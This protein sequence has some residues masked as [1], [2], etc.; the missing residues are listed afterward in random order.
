MYDC[1]D[2]QRK[3]CKTN[4]G[5]GRKI[6]EKGICE[7][8]HKQK[9]KLAKL[10]DGAT[11]VDRRNEKKYWLSAILMMERGITYYEGNG[12]FISTAGKIDYY[13]L[14]DIYLNNLLP[15]R[16]KILDIQIS[17][18]E[19][20]INEI[21]RYIISLYDLVDITVPEY[22]IDLYGPYISMPLLTFIRDNNIEG[23][24]TIRE[25]FK[26]GG[27]IYMK[28]NIIYDLIFN[29]IKTIEKEIIKSIFG[30]TYLFY[31]NYFYRA[32]L[33]IKNDEHR[34][35]KLF[36][37]VGHYIKNF[38]EHKIF[39][40]NN[41]LTEL[42]IKKLHPTSEFERLL[43]NN[44]TGL[45]HNTTAKGGAI[46]ATS[47]PTL[48]NIQ[49]MGQTETTKQLYQTTNINNNNFKLSKFFES[50]GI[51]DTT[52]LI[53]IIN[54]NKLMDV[55]KNYIEIVNQKDKRNTNEASE[56]DKKYTNIKYIG[57]S[58][59]DP[60]T[61]FNTFLSTPLKEKQKTPKTYTQKGLKTPST[62]VAINDGSKKRTKKSKRGSSRR[63]RTK[64]YT[65][66]T[67]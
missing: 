52:S 23:T 58:T 37:L 31:T 62:Q 17:L 45:A 60:K 40:V 67:I 32:I 65:K 25:L 3:I 56:F 33:D 43:R 11:I 10:I 27:L 28:F 20:P 35:K 14:F 19:N 64:Y 13:T 34:F 50:N 24:T 66:K 16:Q 29:I 61:T 47:I 57:S 44:I 55:M 42:L 63:N 30:S 48:T 21:F 51:K 4:F 53:K 59:K 41:L 39:P 8:Y 5:T 49:T 26:P 15:A 36:K 6:L 54:D 38:A 12:F 18:F 9:F 7:Y 46:K 22:M 2:E 1:D